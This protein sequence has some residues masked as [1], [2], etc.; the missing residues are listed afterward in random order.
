MT[1]EPVLPS[2]RLTQTRG[3][4]ALWLAQDAAAR[5][6]AA[7]DLAM[8]SPARLLGH[9]ANRLAGVALGAVADGLTQ[10]AAQSPART[11]AHA[12]G[13]AGRALLLPTA[14]DH[15][16][17]L[18]GSAAVGG[19]LLALGCTNALRPAG[20]GRWLA[21]WALPGLARAV[22]QGLRPAGPGAD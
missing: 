8:A 15:P 5:T 7:A 19:A 13:D 12:A 17:A 9:T 4:I 20:C 16:W 14:K 10:R 11:L 1:T 18:V 21:Q 2:Q 22:V 3:E 6:P